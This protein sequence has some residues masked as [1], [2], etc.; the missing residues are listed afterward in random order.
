M[1]SNEPRQYKR[2][3]CGSGELKK[4][5]T[6]PE[7]DNSTLGKI[8]RHI[9]KNLFGFLTDHIVSSPHSFQDLDE[10]FFNSRVPENPNFVSDEAEFLLENIVA[11]VCS[12]FFTKI[13]W[14]HDI[15]TS[16]LHATYI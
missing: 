16:L 14:T 2:A 8:D 15:C 6:V 4:I 1:V 13:Y 10:H 5:F 3:N 9:S 7:S 12:H 11:E